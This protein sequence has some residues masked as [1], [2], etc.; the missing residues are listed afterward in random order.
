MKDQTILIIDRLIEITKHRDRELI[1]NSL[2]KTI[3]ELVPCRE[4]RI[5]TV[6]E[7]ATPLNLN[8]IVRFDSS[9]FGV[10][11][12]KS[13][14][15]LD[16]KA[17]SAV[18]TSLATN[19]SFILRNGDDKLLKIV[20]PLFL[21]DTGISGFL[22]IVADH[23]LSEYGILVHGLIKIYRNFMTLLAESRLDRLTGLYN[24]QTFESQ[25]MKIAATPVG[26]LCD[27]ISAGTRRRIP[28]EA[29]GYWMAIFDI[30]HFKR[31]NDKFGHIYGDEVLV[32][33]ARI[34]RSTFRSHDLLFRY[35]G[36][37]FIVVLAA[38]S[39]QDAGSAL[40]RF[41]NA[42]AEYHFPQ[43]DSV[44]ISIGYVGITAN[45]IPVVMLGRADKALYYAK[46]HG[47]NMTCSYEELIA[48]G[49]LPP[50]EEIT[51]GI[52]LFCLF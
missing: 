34:M 15:E 51:G 17:A 25:I 16:F 29:F 44:T 7:G 31:I 35:G 32:L 26:R 41:R 14:Q 40:E 33:L 4:V 3:F 13:H 46:E 11:D 50:E 21:S 18:G 6:V 37:E 36:E 47:R 24:R 38:P 5:Y 28:D 49:A 10:S 48:Q 1:E 27:K 8:M 2:V 42:V 43:I 45:E 9:G 30:D 23:E 22:M 20:Y 39:R 12:D 19:G 52:E